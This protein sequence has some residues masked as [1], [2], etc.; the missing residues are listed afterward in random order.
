MIFWWISNSRSCY[1]DKE[2][3]SIGD[4][5]NYNKLSFAGGNKTVYGFKNFKS[6]ERLIKNFHNR[7]MTI[8][9]EE[10]KQS[11]FFENIDKLRAYPA[12]FLDIFTLRKAFL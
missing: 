11:N 3:K 4:N 5:V 7:N 9:E 8:D 12:C 1:F 10:I 6:L 2:I